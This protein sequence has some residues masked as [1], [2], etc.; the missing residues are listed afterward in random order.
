METPIPHPDRRQ[1]LARASAASAF[2]AVHTMIAGANPMLE[3][4]EVQPEE[5]GPRLLSLELVS[6][7]PLAQMKAFYQRV[8]WLSC[9]LRDTV[10]SL[11]VLQDGTFAGN[12][13]P[14]GEY[15]KY[16]I[17]LCGDNRCLKWKSC[18]TRRRTKPFPF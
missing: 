11:I 2:F 5:T 7:V 6:S 12:Y 10:T 1:F 4:L 15:I 9:A 3:A 18:S 16:D 14:R 8:R 13:Y 17:I